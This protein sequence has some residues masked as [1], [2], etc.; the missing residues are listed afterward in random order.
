MIVVVTAVAA[1]GVAVVAEVIDKLGQFG[2]Y[3]VLF[4]SLSNSQCH[5][6]F[7]EKN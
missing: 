6:S 3:E 5:T 2:N 1:I 7:C 4:H